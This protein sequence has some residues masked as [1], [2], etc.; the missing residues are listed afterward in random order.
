MV[1]EQGV[2]VYSMPFDDVMSMMEESVSCYTCHG[3]NPGDG[4]KLTVTH[5]YVLTA[6]GDAVNDIQP[7]VMACGQCH[8]EYHFT[9]S[10]SETMMPYHDVA[11]MT[12]EAIL[13]YYNDMDFADW[14]QES[15]GARMLKAQHPELETFLQGRHA[16]LLT[17]AD[18]H[19]ELTRA[20][21]GTVYHSHTLLSPLESKTILSTC[22]TCHGSTDMVT[23]VHSIQ[24]R[25]T[26]RET[27]VGNKLSGLKDA[28]AAANAAGSLDEETLDQVRA[29]YREAQWFFDY[30]YVENAEGAHN[31]E[32]AYRCLDTSESK[33]DEAMAILE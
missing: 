3:N 11:G 30:C 8:I 19:M 22:T 2:G 4:G 16:S 21:D 20:E 1:Q 27:E 5:T 33:I 32:L 28:L 26:A 12:P 9:P 23:F 6:L 29:M 10:D 24:S 7:A 25:V 14:T 18:C 17:C 31:S 15:T 13:Q